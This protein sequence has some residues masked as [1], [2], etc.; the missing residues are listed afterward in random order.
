MNP[1]LIL[2]VFASVAVFAGMGAHLQKARTAKIFHIVGGALGMTASIAF[3]LTQH[4]LSWAFIVPFV[5]AMI[6][7]GRALGDWARGRV[8]FQ[9]PAQLFFLAGTLS[10]LGAL[11]TLLVR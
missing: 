8:S 3:A 5:F 4:K 7:A 10:L 2:L 11:S 6:F 1:L 9:P